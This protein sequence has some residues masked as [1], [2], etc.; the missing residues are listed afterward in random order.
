MQ[1]GDLDGAIGVYREL[2]AGAEGTAD[3][4]YNLGM[5]L[6]QKD[7]FTEAET[8]L[9]KAIAK[10]PSLPEAHFTLGV[11]LWQT[12]RADDALRSFD[13]AI[14]QRADY[15]EAHYMRATV[16]KQQ[17]RL[18]EAIAGFREAIRRQPASA[19]AHLSLGQALQQR[20]DPAAAASLAEAERL[21][22]KKADAQAAAFA[23]S[24]GRGRMHKGDVAGAV[25]SF[26]EA[27][28]PRSG[29]RRGALPARARPAQAGSAGRGAPAPRRGPPPRALPRAA[30]AD[31]LIACADSRSSS[32]CSRR[33]SLLRGAALGQEG[34]RS[35]GFSFT[36]V[37]A[38]AGL[39]A[40]TVFGGKETNKYLLE[41]TGCG[42]AFFDYDGDGWQ[43]VFLVNG[44]TLEGFPKGQEPTNHLYRNRGDGTFEDT[45]RK[46]GLAQGGWGQGVCAG[47]YDNDGRED[48]FVSYFGQNRLYHNRGGRHLRR[49]EPE[50]GAR[51]RP[52]ALGDGLRVPRLRPRLQPG[53]R[54]RQLHRPG[55]G[56]RS[57]ARLGSVPLQGD[58]GGVRPTGAARR[59]ERPLSQPGRRH[60]RGRLREVGDHEG[61]RDL[62]P[63]REHPRFR[64]RRLDRPL[65][66]QRLQSQRALPQQPGRHVHRRGRHRGLRL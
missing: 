45:T 24:A 57:H 52:H 51:R 37:A 30:G 58:Q 43:D 4:H 33:A 7:E 56:H 50:G 35:P 64:R 3:D 39:E 12:G 15:A 66:G 46:A 60:L 41:T 25:A 42:A 10:D 11:V 21:N 55:P 63:G 53:P 18:D 59:Q 48:L 28:R 26:R 5:A 47:D 34:A 13:D 38:R 32:S 27:V 40:A 17:G 54:R 8:E 6:K 20:R 49:R 14:A 22:K 61:Q 16:L 9:R 31:G 2:L 19:E 65:R 1:K 62:R 23:L 44:T 29:E 36:N